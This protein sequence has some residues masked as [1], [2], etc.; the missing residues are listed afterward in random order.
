MLWQ[1]CQEMVL[2][3]CQEFWR[4]GEIDGFTLS[5]NTRIAWH[6]VKKGVKR[7]REVSISEQAENARLENNSDV[8][9]EALE[10]LLSRYRMYW[11][12]GAPA[13]LRSSVVA[14]RRGF[15]RELS[16]L[17]K[18]LNLQKQG[19]FDE[20]NEQLSQSGRGGGKVEGM[21]YFQRAMETINRT[22]YLY[23]HNI[24]ADNMDG[25]QSVELNEINE[26]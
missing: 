7:L 2:T 3:H 1:K 21:L 12:E 9:L 26:G 17:S 10:D 15:V 18:A 20:H 14:D 13:S 22:R 24:Q 8:S 16:S 6:M 23:R 25:A 4:P 5:R 19:K 11:W